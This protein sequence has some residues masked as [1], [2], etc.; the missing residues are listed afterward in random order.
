MAKITILE[1]ERDGFNWGHGVKTKRPHLQPTKQSVG[2]NS[3]VAPSLNQSSPSQAIQR[4]QAKRGI[5]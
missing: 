3:R 5:K 4:L 1:G 2:L